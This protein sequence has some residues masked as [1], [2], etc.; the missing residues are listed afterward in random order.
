MML[1]NLNNPHADALLMP[2]A[3]D[4]FAALS[5]PRGVVLAP[6]TKPPLKVMFSTAH[7]VKKELFKLFILGDVLKG[8]SRCTAYS[9][10]RKMLWTEERSVVADQIIAVRRKYSHRGDIG[11]G[12]ACASSCRREFSRGG[13]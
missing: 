4:Y 2:T 9:D 7:R 8:T 5:G 1:F 6:H 10:C 12:H 13:Y 3:F 11:P